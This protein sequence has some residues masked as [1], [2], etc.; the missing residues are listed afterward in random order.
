MTRKS[1]VRMLGLAAVAVLGSAEVCQAQTAVSRTSYSYNRFGQMVGARIEIALP[2][3]NRR[4]VFVVPAAFFRLPVKTQVALLDKRFGLGADAKA[5]AGVLE[6]LRQSRQ[7]D[8]MRR[9][10]DNLLKTAQPP[11]TIPQPPL[12]Q[13]PITIPGGPG[14]APLN[15]PQ[16]PIPQ[17]PITIPR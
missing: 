17:P 9:Q 1:L 8:E 13:P 6:S 16:A 5:V 14:M 2:P 4:Y 10:M 7:L 11:I 12:M 15:I 3:V